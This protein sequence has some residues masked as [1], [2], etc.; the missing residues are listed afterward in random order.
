MPAQNF[1]SR[2]LR[3]RTCLTYFVLARN[4]RNDLVQLDADNAAAPRPSGSSAA[5]Y[6]GCRVRC[7]HCCPSPRSIGSFT[8]WPDGRWK[9]SS[10]C[11]SACTVYS[12]GGSSDRRLERVAEHARV[13]HPFVARLQALDVEAEAVRSTGSCRSLEG[14]ARDRRPSIRS[15]NRPSTASFD[16]FGRIRTAN[17]PAGC[18][19]SP[20]RRDRGERQRAEDEETTTARHGPCVSVL[21]EHLLHVLLEAPRGFRAGCRT[22]GRRD[23]RAPARATNRPSPASDRRSGPS[24]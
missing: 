18:T 3:I 20:R 17:P 1:D 23:T 2:S 15:N 7:F 14:A 8:V 12:P 19:S 13:E 6:R 10:L 22:C 24:P 4:R 11:R 9:V 16:R 5:C 21:R